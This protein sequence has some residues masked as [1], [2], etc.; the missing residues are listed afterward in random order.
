MRLLKRPLFCSPEVFAR[1]L[2][3]HELSLQNACKRGAG[4][5][6]APTIGILCAQ[7][8]GGDEEFGD[9]KSADAALNDTLNYPWQ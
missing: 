8:E 4:M 2:I 9:D 5:L 6:S 7:I 1:A 3:Q